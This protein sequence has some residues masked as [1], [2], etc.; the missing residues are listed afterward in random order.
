MNSHN[1]TGNASVGMF[2]VSAIQKISGKCLALQPVIP[3]SDKVLK[4]I[5]HNKLLSVKP[6][7]I[8]IHLRPRNV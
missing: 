3:V 8:L 4:G 6:Y 2:C 7:L 5:F 1:I